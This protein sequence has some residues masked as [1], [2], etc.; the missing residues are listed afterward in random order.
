MAEPALNSI[1]DYESYLTAVLAGWSPRQRLAF[2]AGMA[3]RWLPVYAAFS[4]AEQWGDAEGLRRSLAAVWAHLA[5]RPLG[6]ADRT[7]HQQLLRDS[8]PH[9]DDFDALEALIA[10][11]LLRAALEACGTTDNT[12]HAL[13]AALAG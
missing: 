13:G 5:G 4:A 3:E 1:D 9:M 10:C 2:T 7:R 11:D 8:T 12:Q 6:A